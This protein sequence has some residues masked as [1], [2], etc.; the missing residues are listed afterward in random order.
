MT[1]VLVGI[2][3]LGVVV[4]V[5]G[6]LAFFAMDKRDVCQDRQAELEAAESARFG[7]DFWYIG[8]DVKRSDAHQLSGVTQGPVK[9]VYFVTLPNGTIHTDGNHR[10]LRL[11]KLDYVVQPGWS[12]LTF[13]GE[14]LYQYRV[15]LD[16]ATYQ[17][18]LLHWL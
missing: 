17:L 2:L 15:R 18:L 4:L 1:M 8:L 11:I 3:I 9:N 6:A 16:Q 7:T 10:L 13:Q 5:L 12:T 14:R